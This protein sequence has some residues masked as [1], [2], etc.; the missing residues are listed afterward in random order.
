[1]DSGRFDMS[2]LSRS[3]DRRWIKV[4]MQSGTL[5]IIEPVKSK[6]RMQG[7]LLNMVFS[8]LTDLVQ[9]IS[10]VRAL[11]CSLFVMGRVMESLSVQTEMRRNLNKD[12]S[13]NDCGSPQKK[14]S[15]DKC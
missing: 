13:S 10:N 3:S 15:W 8:T 9:Q 14:S 1:M 5:F 12:L 7:S 6:T 11:I 2:V 4:P